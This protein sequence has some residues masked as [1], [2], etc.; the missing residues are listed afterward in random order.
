[1]KDTGSERE[2]DADEKPDTESNSRSNEV[3]GEATTNPNHDNP[4]EENKESDEEIWNPHN[5]GESDEEIW[6]PHDKEESE[7]ETWDPHDKEESEEEVWAPHD[8]EDT[9]REASNP[10]EN[11]EREPDE[12][13]NPSNE[14]TTTTLVTIEQEHDS[15]EEESQSEQESEKE[16]DPDYEQ[17]GNELELIK[18]NDSEHS[19]ETEPEQEHEVG[20]ESEEHWEIIT[21]ESEVVEK[22]IENLYE[23]ELEPEII[24][25]QEIK[26]L[27]DQET[28]QIPEQET[29]TVPDRDSEIIPD[30]DLELVPDKELKKI[31][32][33]AQKKKMDEKSREEPFIISNVT[34]PDQLAYVRRLD[35]LRELINTKRQPEKKKKGVKKKKKEEKS[36]QEPYVITTVKN[37][38][39]LAHVRGLDKLRE[40]VDPK[41]PPEKK[42]KQVPKKKQ[43]SKPLK[44]YGNRMKL[45]DPEEVPEKL[46]EKT[47]KKLEQGDEQAQKKMIEIRK[48][49]EASEVSPE[50]IENE[51]PPEKKEETT[52][53]PI[54]SEAQ[55][56]K[57]SQLQSQSQQQK[58]A[59]SQPQI[60]KQRTKSDE[61]SKKKGKKEEWEILLKI[62]VSEFNTKVIPDEIKKEL[63]KLIRKY[64]KYQKIIEQLRVLLR[65]QT[66]SEEEFEVL[67]ALY[68]KLEQ[69]TYIEILMFG[70][71]RSFQ[72]FYAQFYNWQRYLIFA[73]NALFPDFLAKKLAFL[74]NN[75]DRR[76]YEKFL[77]SERIK[78]QKIRK[79]PRIVFDASVWIQ[80]GGSDSP[81]LPL[82]KNFVAQLKRIL[83]KY[84]IIESFADKFLEAL[85][86]GERLTYIRR[87]MNA[88]RHKRANIGEEKLDFWLVRIY[89][90][91]L[92]LR[93]K[94]K[95]ERAL[96]EIEYI[97]DQ[98]YFD[99]AYTSKNPLYRQTRLLLCRI[100]DILEKKNFT[101]LSRFLQYK[102]ERIY[103]KMR[104]NNSSFPSISTLLSKI[105]SLAVPTLS[106]QKNNKLT[107]LIIEY[108]S[109][110]DYWAKLKALRKPIKSYR[111][112]LIYNLLL[113]LLRNSLLIKTISLASLSQLFFGDRNYLTN[114]FLASNEILMRPDYYVLMRIKLLTH[115][116]TVESLRKE[117]LEVNDI[118]LITLKQEIRN[119]VNRFMLGN[120][121]DVPYIHEYPKRGRGKLTRYYNKQFLLHELDLVSELFTAYALWN[122][123]PM[124]T[125]KYFEKNKIY[126]RSLTKL[127]SQGNRN[128]GRKKLKKFL[129]QVRKFYREAIEG[130]YQNT[131]LQIPQAELIQIYKQAIIQMIKYKR[132]RRIR[133][134]PIPKDYHDLWE[135]DWVIAYHVILL[136]ARQLGFNILTFKPLEDESFDKSI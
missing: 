85:V 45:E 26:S 43:N 11:L 122:D 129:H 16:P 90:K 56:Q 104:A 115:I 32:K 77:E 65:K 4:K 93:S 88:T 48:E 72:A 46:P 13:E 14:G 15:T 71:L 75:P 44:L 102:V 76:A 8:K 120:P 103:K 33:Q 40:L 35:K 9:D 89:D 36:R 80:N 116:M 86:K 96:L 133:F 125:F 50:P 87:D 92:E 97:F 83:Q 23:P 3:S 105:E 132:E 64:R 99:S 108:I 118:E 98:Y 12:S 124:L 70:N 67:E 20:P 114:V 111:E 39:H 117:G 61:A 28:E 128:L 52:S 47:E 78:R 5:D 69:F 54:E 126:R 127:L 57:Q 95:R 112:Y 17:P 81:Y 27:P 79:A 119:E 34:N 59:P 135:T 60:S 21:P 91:L 51:Q 73:E 68:K 66:L 1:M 6:N 22:A 63:I 100:A 29:E 131:T 2:E 136:F 62:W 84:G 130:T 106:R 19:P 123:D 18:P 55:P 110:Y 31:K 82:F 24:P 25:E 113:I 38:E 49:A 58:Q 94:K 37:P 101:A 42:K 53:I 41:H 107:T 109:K 10:E 134:K 74:K 121:Y 7:E 30:E